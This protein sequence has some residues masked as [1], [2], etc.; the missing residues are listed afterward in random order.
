MDNF[1]TVLR[2][3]M[4]QK[5]TIGYS[6]MALLT[7]GGER[8]FT[9]V[10]FQCPCNHDQ[11]FA[12]GMTFLLGPAAVLLVLGL[13]VNN[14]LWRL[15]TGCCLNPMKLCPRGNCLGCSRVLMSIISGACVAPVMWLSVALLNGTFY[16]CA[17]SGLDENLV[18]NLFCKNK[19]MNCPEE[20]ARV[21]C[22]RSKLS[23]DERMELL[24]MLRAQSQILGWTIIIVSAVVGL[25]GTCF[26][27]CR[28]R[29]SYLQLTFWKR[30]MEKENERFDALSV[31]YANKLAERNL[32]SFFEN[33]K[34]APMPFPNHKAW[35]EISAYYTFSSREQYYSILQRYVETSDFPPERKP[36]LE[37]ET[38][39][40]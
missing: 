20:L 40:S 27:N 14:R 16:E 7:I 31:E 15:Y 28:S 38:A 34:P 18:V 37:C 2:F 6:F 8:L 23:S 36:I 17:I 24:L 4:N 1:Q 35:E 26:K 39:T 5:A 21:P 13:F 9:L 12:Y 22:D 30:Y 29:V 3:F 19:T 25:V 11:N 32:K 33:N 10:S